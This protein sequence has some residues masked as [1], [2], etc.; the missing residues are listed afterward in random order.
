M[1][2][3][4]AYNPNMI[5]PAGTQ[6]VTRGAVKVAGRDAGQHEGAVGVITKSPADHL[7]SYRVR[8]PDGSEAALRRTQFAVLKHVQRDRIWSADNVLDE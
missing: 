6:V 3:K 7:H 1:A 8:F 2:R 4:I 5:L